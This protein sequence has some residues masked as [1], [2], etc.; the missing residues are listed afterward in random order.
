MTLRLRG[1][2]LWLALLLSAGLTVYG[3]VHNRLFTQRLWTPEGLHRFLLFAGGYLVAF[4]AFHF[5]RPAWF[6][7][8]VWI[9]T[10]AYT[11]AAIG[12]APIFSAGLFL[13]ACV[14]LGQSILGEKDQPPVPAMLLGLC[15]Y[16]LAASLAALVPVNYPLV[17][18]AALLVPLAWNYR[19]TMQWLA[20]AIGVFRPS[21][22][23]PRSAQLGFGELVFCLLAQWLVMLEPEAGTDALAMHLVVPSNMATLHRWAFDVTDHIWAVMP[24]G[25]DWCF[26]IVYLLGGEMAARLL[27]FAFLLAMVVVLVSI[28]RRW[29]PAGTAYLLA[30]LFAATPLVQLL[31][32]SLFVE[33]LWALVA[34]GAVTSLAASIEQKDP[35][36][37]IVAFVLVGGA[38]ATKF[39]ALALAAPMLAALLW[40]VW[41]SRERRNA[42]ITAGA[43]LAC[44][45]IFAAPPYL[46]AYAKTGNP[47]FPFLN[48]I[49]RSPYFGTK[50]SFANALYRT[51][52]SLRTPYDITFHTVHFL[53][54]QDGAAGFQYLLLLPLAY[55]AIRRGWPR[56]AIVTALVLPPFFVLVYLTQSNLRYLY[57]AMPLATI[58]IAAGLAALRES[59]TGLYRAVWAVSVPVLLLN[60]YFLP[61]SGW[62]HNDFQADPVTAAGRARYL[63][64]HA[65]VRR[66]ID[67]LNA[68]HPGAPVALIGTTDMAGLRGRAFADNWHTNDFNTRLWIARSEQ[69][70]LR[71][72][73]ERG[74]E[75]LVAP[76][77]E[78]PIHWL[79]EFVTF[80]TETELAGT[81]YYIARIRTGEPCEQP[82]AI[83]TPAIAGRYHSRDPHVIYTGPWTRGRFKEASPGFVSYTDV[84]GASFRFN[85]AGT[86]VTYIY[87]RAYNRGIAEI[88]LDGEK[89]AE[90]DLYAPDIK[91][92]AA[93]D[94]AASAPGAHTL[95]VRVTGRKNPAA[96][97]VFV[98]LDALVVR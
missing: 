74:I 18:L 34:L 98:D 29:L 89:R 13:L 69:D 38:T 4:L 45:L 64:A 33:N 90:L 54:G 51:P 81:P 78:I 12:L 59:D 5:L 80:C 20:R 48:G 72:L 55:L 60:L 24:M 70:I 22:P 68:H 28:M 88:L 85:F 65:P 16:M 26:S 41:R 95:E 76:R 3:L 50:T 62:L 77:D 63:Q 87:T 42:W 57:A 39:G 25:A 79:Q 66:L 10:L 7:P 53:E 61:S 96:T 86:V 43:A 75:E 6:A 8:L 56:L 2:T 47:V 17:Y 15:L 32:G 23:G 37:L 82:P 91:W 19:L 52:L 27:N 36:L 71:L 94:F 83:T 35:R 49:F 67:Y 92:Q 30:A 40:T 46:T 84:P 31:T 14:V 11:A 73:R 58:V 97:G 9:S 93:T 21:A 1:L 44:F